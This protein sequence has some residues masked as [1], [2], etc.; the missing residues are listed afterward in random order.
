LC[1]CETKIIFTLSLTFAFHKILAHSGSLLLMAVKKN[2]EKKE[3]LFQSN[4]LRMSNNPKT[5]VYGCIVNC[6]P[7][8]QGLY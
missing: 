3:A 2:A 1:V 8:I 7:P 4:T 6:K 5:C